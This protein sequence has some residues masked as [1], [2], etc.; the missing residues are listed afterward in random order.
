[1]KIE[2]MQYSIAMK[3]IAVKVGLIFRSSCFLI[4]VYVLFL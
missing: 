3:A 4:C 1:M 2:L